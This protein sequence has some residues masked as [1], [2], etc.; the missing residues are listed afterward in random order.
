MEE[1]EVMWVLLLEKK[2]PY[3]EHDHDGTRERLSSE[4]MA[5]TEV[6]RHA[7][8]KFR[9]WYNSNVKLSQFWHQ[10]AERNSGEENSKREVNLFMH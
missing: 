5:K 8:F 6:A 2:Q 4:E 10:A 7:L 9:C 3:L 1:S